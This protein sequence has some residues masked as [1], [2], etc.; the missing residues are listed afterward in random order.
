MLEKSQK[1]GQK[2]KKEQSKSKSRKARRRHG[3]LLLEFNRR[4]RKNLWLET[5][6][7][8]AKRFHMVKRWGYCLGDGPTYKCYRACYRAMSSHCLLQVSAFTH[9]A[10]FY[11]AGYLE[12]HVGT[13][14]RKYVGL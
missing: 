4:Q 8:H 9:G 11:Q 1:A 7:W 14:D 10:P 6:V 2:V 3:N 13:T 5:H 12:K